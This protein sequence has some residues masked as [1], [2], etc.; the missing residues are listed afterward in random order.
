MRRRALLALAAASLLPARAFAG[1]QQYEPMSESVRNAL[2]RI[3]AYRRTPVLHFSNSNDAHRWSLEMNKRLRDYMPERTDRDEFLKTVH[4]YGR[5]ANL[6]PQLVLGLIHVESRYQRYAVSSAG[7]MGYMQVMP[8]WV[9]VIGAPNDRLFDMR[10]NIVYGC[11]IMRH[12]LD[13]ENG[14][15]FRALGRYNGSLGK[16]EYPNLVYASWKGRWGYDGATS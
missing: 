6:D 1:A 16:P 7:A 10:T 9:K 12:Y 5:R 13:I 3:V 15:Y 11:A 4:Y 14:D 2:R 8:F